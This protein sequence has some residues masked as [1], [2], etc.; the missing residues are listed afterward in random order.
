[1]SIISEVSQELDMDEE[2]FREQIRLASGKIKYIKLKKK[3][4]GHRKI[5]IPPWEFKIVQYW[6]ILNYLRSI[7]VHHSATAFKE[8]ASIRI[9]AMLHRQGN[10]FVKMDISNFFPSVG[11]DDFKH[12][13]HKYFP[14]KA[15]LEKE[16]EDKDF[17]E[18]MFHHGVCA[19]GFPV[20]PYIANISMF[21]LDEIIENKLKNNRDRFGSFCYTR[22]ADDITISISRKGFKKDVENL[23]YESVGESTCKGIKINSSKTKYG[24]KRGGSAFITGIRICKDD[25]LTLHRKY[26]D[27]VRLLLSLYSK[28]RLKP[29]DKSKLLGHLNYCKS[30]DPEFYNRLV[31][32][33]FHPIEKLKGQKD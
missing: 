1:M 31:M 7:E 26:K 16:L 18:A 25:R 11:V 15:F 21:E 23:V 28:G 2:S 24:S 8:G 20:S 27:H 17:T 29:E 10:Y 4:G 12:A 5:I 14:D 22:Y 6:T 33:Y 13:L 32:K 9:N 30:S 19:I 3:G